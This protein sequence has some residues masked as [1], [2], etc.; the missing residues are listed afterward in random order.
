VG[1]L[2]HQPRDEVQAFCPHDA[3][4]GESSVKTAIADFDRD[5]GIGGRQSR[6]APKGSATFGVRSAAGAIAAS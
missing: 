2:L 3:L 6:A 4:S 1:A 5:V